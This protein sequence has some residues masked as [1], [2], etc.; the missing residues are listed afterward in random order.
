MRIDVKDFGAIADGSRTTTRELQA[1]I[2]ACAAAGG[3]TVYVGAGRYVTGSL[4]MRS[5]LTLELDAG[6]TLLGSED[7]ADFPEW[8]SKWEGPGVKPSPAALICGEDLDNVAVTGR[9]TIDGRGKVWWDAQ[10]AAL[11]RMRETASGEE[12]R[13]PNLFRLVNSRNVFLTGITFCNSPFWTVSPLACDNVTIHAITIRNPADSPNTD[14]INPDSCRNVRISDCH[15]DVGDDCITIKSGKE[16]D[17]RATLK[18]CENITVTNCTLVHGHGGVV[19][20]SEMS[21]GV[22][23]VTISNCVFYG[24]DRGIR[25][26]ARRGRGGFVEDV[27]VSNLV[28]DQVLCPIAV[29]LFYGC[30]AWDSESVNNPNAMPVNDGTPR[31]R[32]IRFSGISARRTKVAAAYILGLPEQYV[33]DIAL[34][35]VSVEMDVDNTTPG[36][37]DMSPIVEA[38]CRAG[39]IARN[40]RGLTMR[41][42]SVSYSVGPALD[43]TDAEQLLVAEFHARESVDS[44]EAVRLSN[45]RHAVVE[46]LN[47]S[48]QLAHAIGIGGRGTRR[49]TIRN[50]NHDN[51]GVGTLLRRDADVRD[52]EIRISGNDVAA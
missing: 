49:V 27:R 11:I 5:N 37:P 50:C 28:M 10:F 41:D 6:A 21:G 2:D 24:T 31:F 29:N 34:H 40:V 13:R 23:N 4:W 20:G 44:P 43:V 36:D 42:V 15:V 25:L 14:G 35:D 16:D 7:F 38:R 45:V 33:E 26:K 8:Q 3:G 51:A 22:R 17:G 47:G 46:G 9:G 39:V 48:S 18:T 32:H 19:M 52:G 12:C 30:G 1:A